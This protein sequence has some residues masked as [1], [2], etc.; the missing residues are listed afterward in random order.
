MTWIETHDGTIVNLERVEAIGVNHNKEKGK[1]NVILT[2]CDESYYI[3]DICETRDEAGFCLEAIPEAI[4]K[5]EKTVISYQ[6]VMKIIS[7]Y[8]DTYYDEEKQL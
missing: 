6:D 3:F 7:R 1:Y 8:G 4:C 5:S 2:V